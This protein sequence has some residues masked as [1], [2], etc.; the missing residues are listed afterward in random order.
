MIKVVVVNGSP[1]IHKGNTGFVL[2]HFIKGLKDG[3]ASVEILYPSKLDIKPC[4]GNLSCW[5]E[6]K[7]ECIIQDDMQTIYPLLKD[8]DVLIFASPVYVPQPGM[9]Q[10]F[11]NRLCPLFNPVLSFIDGRTRIKYHDD[12]KISK[13]L[14]IL[15]SGWW[16]I[17]NLSLLLKIFEEYAAIT[18]TEFSGA[19]LRPHAYLLKKD[20][21]L[22]Q[23]ILSKLEILGKDFI[24]NGS[25]N[26]ADLQFISQPLSSEEE[27]RQNWNH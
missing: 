25:L 23:A 5:D 21:E 1:H 19:V 26:Q 11:L 15:T 9:M 16:E 17:E 27:Y 20:T 18:K 4:L 10:I 3:G 13:I 12:V 14:A 2:E 7:G 22:N 6:T 8:A 24:L